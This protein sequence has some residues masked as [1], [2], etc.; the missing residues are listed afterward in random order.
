[1]SQALRARRWIYRAAYVVLALV[2][3]LLHLMPLGGQAGDWPGPDV[4]LCITLAWTLRR[5]QAMALWL[6]VIVLFAEDLLLMRPPGLWTAVVIAG[7]EFLRTRMAFTRELNLFSE[8]LMMAGLIVTMKLVY[9]FVFG[10]ALLP[11][12][13]LGYS[14][15]EALA[16]I[17]CYPVVV[18][19][20]AI[21]MGLHKPATGEIDA[22]GRRM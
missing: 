5:P 12:V 19:A 1:M 15:I 6:I 14:M 11:Q 22:Y 13:P 8:W 9:R 18:L 20:S 16:T 21:I 4:L 2:I 7:T 17:L 10:I 3:V